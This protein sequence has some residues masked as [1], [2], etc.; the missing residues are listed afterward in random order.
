MGNASG[1]TISPRFRAPVSGADVLSADV[2]G[3][4]VSLSVRPGWLREVARSILEPMLEPSPAQGANIEGTIVAFEASD[5][6]R[7][8]AADAVRLED[9]DPLLELYRS[10]DGE[11]FWLVD[12]RWGMCE[13]NLLRRSWRSWILP[14]PSCDPVRLFES[15]IV[16]PMAQLLRGLGLHLIPAAGVGLADKGVLMLS[17]FDVGLEMRALAD[18]G[19]G[20]IGQ[21]WVALRQEADGQMSLLWFP[22]RTEIEPAPRLLSTG[23]T[24]GAKWIDATTG[25]SARHVCLKARCSLVLLVE[26]MRRNRCGFD[27]VP[28]AVARDHLRSA[29]PMPQLSSGPSAV[30]PNLLPSELAGQCPVHRV[31]LSRRGEDLVGMLTGGQSRAAA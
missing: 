31:R 23:R 13:I 22:G 20:V 16:W 10:R 8:V 12:E 18:A 6:L 27:A 4:P 9:A 1:T 21:R 30:S 14:D 29:W 2:H 28:F 7:H 19:I 11:R 15:A 5:V 17:P 25:N 3:H 24:D 26:P